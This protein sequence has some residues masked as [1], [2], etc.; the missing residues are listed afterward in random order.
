MVLF[1]YFKREKNNLSDPHG[2]LAQSVPSTSIA[3][4]NSEVRS[5]IESQ[6]NKK[7][8]RYA[9][10]TPEQTSMIGKRATE[11]HVYKGCGLD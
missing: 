3:T 5:V 9:M 2:V 8:G 4:A 7:R 1:P 11:H 10:Y 6:N